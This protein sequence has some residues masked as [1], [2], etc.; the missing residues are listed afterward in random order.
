MT[1]KQI[2]ALAAAPLLMAAGEPAKIGNAAFFA[3]GVVTPDVERTSAEYQRIL[4]VVSEDFGYG[5]VTD[6]QGGL[7]SL[8]MRVV[9]LPNMYIKLHQPVSE[10]GTYTPHLKTHGMS[11]QNMQMPVTGLAD[12]RAEMVRNGGRWSQGG[13]DDPWAYVDF[14]K[15][16]GITLEPV[17]IG[18]PERPVTPAPGAVDPLG[19]MPVTHLGFAVGN[20]RKSAKAFGKIFGIPVP[21]VRTVRAGQFPSGSGW[22]SQARL[23]IASWQQ[24]LIG[25]Q[26]VESVDGPTPWSDYR[27]SQ[28]GDAAQYITF[29]TGDRLVETLA[30]LQ[31]KGGKLVY[32]RPEDGYALLDFMDSLGLFIKITGSS[33]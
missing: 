23:R 8:K 28:K 1:G 11:I 13:P 22:N 15:Q 24:G 31:A 27:A 29:D 4:G 9:F 20:A 19:A 17:E 33:D 5:E 2:A 7:V 14:R 10:N 26:L 32:G 16:L 21:G 30:D 6:P 12:I 3:I 18:R 25:M